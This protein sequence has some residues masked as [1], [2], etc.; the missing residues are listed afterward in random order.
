MID[1]NRSLISLVQAGEIT[2]ENARLYSMNPKSL[3]RLM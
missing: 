2:L 3:E 1:L